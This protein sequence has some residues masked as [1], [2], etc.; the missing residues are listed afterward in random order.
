[1]GEFIKSN[2]IFRNSFIFV[3]QLSV[4]TFWLGGLGSDSATYFAET[5]HNTIEPAGTV[6]QRN[7]EK[8]SMIE[9]GKLDEEFTQAVRKVQ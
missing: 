8:S 7:D 4:R 2:I 1:M 9:A 6:R 5:G 3:D